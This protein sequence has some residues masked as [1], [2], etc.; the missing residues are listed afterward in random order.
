MVLL[1][2][3]INYSQTQHFFNWFILF[4]NTMSNLLTGLFTRWYVQVTTFRTPQMRSCSTF[5]NF[6]TLLAL[7]WFW[8]NSKSFNPC[9]DYSY[10]SGSK[11]PSSISIVSNVGVDVSCCWI[12]FKDA[13]FSLCLCLRRPSK[14]AYVFEIPVVWSQQDFN[15]FSVRR[16]RRFSVIYL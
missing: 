13:S 9:T 8:K 2:K 12:S 7:L 6:S 14:L 16:R 10:V 1:I 5:L 3:N 15:R 4:V 11:S